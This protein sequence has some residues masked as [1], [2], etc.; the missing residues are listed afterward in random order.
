MTLAR[1]KNIE[2]GTHREKVCLVVSCYIDPIKEELATRRSLSIQDIESMLRNKGPAKP[3]NYP[4]A[5][6]RVTSLTSGKS[7][8][9]DDLLVSHYHSRAGSFSEIRV[10]VYDVNVD[11]SDYIDQ[12]VRIDSVLQSGQS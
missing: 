5:P 9:G 8:V 2:P 10:F 11:L 6:V 12:D 1:C 3:R 4:V 7:F